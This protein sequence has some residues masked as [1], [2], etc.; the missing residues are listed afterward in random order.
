MELSD[1]RGAKSDEG[2]RRVRA[3]A[4]RGLGGRND[5]VDKTDKRMWLV[6][7]RVLGKALMVALVMVAHAY[8][9][10]VLSDYRD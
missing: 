5:A 1:G 6:V 7:S 8:S 3:D 10:W 4:D 9:W 2:V